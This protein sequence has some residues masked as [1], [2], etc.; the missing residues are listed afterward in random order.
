MDDPLRKLYTLLNHAKCNF[1]CHVRNTENN[2]IVFLKKNI[3]KQKGTKNYQ[4]NYC[5]SQSNKL[6]LKSHVKNLCKKSLAKIWG[7]ERL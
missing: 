1:L 2:S 4:N 6:T 7:L 5:Y 3:E